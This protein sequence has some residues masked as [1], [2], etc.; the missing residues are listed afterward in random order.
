RR[1]STPTSSCELAPITCSFRARSRG[2]G[3]WSSSWP[4]GTTASPAE[5]RSPRRQPHSRHARTTGFQECCRRV[6]VHAWRICRLALTVPLRARVLPAQSIPGGGFGGGRRGRLRPDV[7][8]H[9]HASAQGVA[10]K[11]RERQ[12]LHLHH[13]ERRLIGAGAHRLLLGQPLGTGEG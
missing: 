11:I 7:P 6:E 4:N 8:H 12:V 9:A 13:L 2:S 1:R 3:S 5:R 10:G